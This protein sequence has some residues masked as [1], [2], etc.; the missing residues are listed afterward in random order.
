MNEEEI[1]IEEIVKHK[2]FAARILVTLGVV[3][4]ASDGQLLRLCTTLSRYD[5]YQLNL[6]DSKEEKYREVLKEA[7]GMLRTDGY[8]GKES[9]IQFQNKWVAESSTS[10][11]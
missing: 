9:N 11:I 6:A 3:G 2:N 4:I 8:L 7:D 5:K 10:G 1:L